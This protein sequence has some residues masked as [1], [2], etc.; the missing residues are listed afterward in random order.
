[1]ATDPIKEYA[2]RFHSVERVFPKETVDPAKLSWRDI[3]KRDVAPDSWQYKNQ[4]TVKPLKLRATPDTTPVSYQG[5]KGY[6]Y[7]ACDGHGRIKI[8][9]SK[10]PWARMSEA[11]RFNPSIKIVAVEKDDGSSDGGGCLEHRRHQQFKTLHLALE[12]FKADEELWKWIDTL[13]T[14]TEKP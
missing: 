10:N 3:P 8:G 13:K 4:P 12:W 9:F 5:R 11:R 7:Y 6:V 1:M 2:K 14:A